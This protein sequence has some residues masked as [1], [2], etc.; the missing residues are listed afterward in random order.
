MLHQDE[1]DNNNDP[2][3]QSAV[4][5][6][7]KLLEFDKGGA[8]H[9]SIKDQGSDWYELENNTW[10]SQEQRG[11]AKKMREFEEKRKFEQEMSTFVTIGG[12]TGD[13]FVSMKAGEV[14]SQEQISKEANDYVNQLAMDSIQTNMTIEDDEIIKENF[15]DI[16]ITSCQ[17]LDQKSKELMDKL[18][19]DALEVEQH[20]IAASMNKEVNANKE[21]IVES[22]SERLQTENPFDDFKK[23]LD[24]VLKEEEAEKAKKEQ[25]ETQENTEIKFLNLV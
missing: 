4:D 20:I 18:R 16:K 7:N 17:L 2:S 5:M 11:L 10:E 21:G 15:K 13:D 14:K 19:R 24:E 1:E 8:T 25:E 9:S 12:G 23:F 22:L 3:Y 6:R